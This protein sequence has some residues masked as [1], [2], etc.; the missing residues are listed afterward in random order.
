MVKITDQ[1][2]Q[3]LQKHGLSLTKPRK[4]VFG[5]LQGNEPLTMRELALACSEHIDRASLY[6]TVALFERLDIVQRLQ[7]GWKY[8]LELSNTFQEHHHHLTCSICGKMT[9]LHEDDELEQRLQALALAHD[10]TA[11]DHQLE[12]RGVCA[13][14]R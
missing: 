14:C 5:A 4:I 9:P 3:A 1:L 8:R 10:F 6:R 2:Q 12:I 7:I 11:Q 13:D